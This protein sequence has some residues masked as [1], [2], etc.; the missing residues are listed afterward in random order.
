L[1]EKEMLC[2]TNLFASYPPNV[3]EHGVLLPSA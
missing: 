1:S 3:K 2:G